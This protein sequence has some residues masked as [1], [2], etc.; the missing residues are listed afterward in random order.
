MV[1]ALTLKVRML[2]SLLH[3]YFLPPLLLSLMLLVQLLSHR[4][5]ELVVYQILELHGAL[6]QPYLGTTG[7][8]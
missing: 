5:M 1:L 7:N 4:G 8:V 2:T 6:R 3:L